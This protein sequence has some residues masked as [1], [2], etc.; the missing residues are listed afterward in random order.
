MTDAPRTERGNRT[1]AKLLVAAEAVF[2]ECGYSDAS[3]VRITEAAG[4]A[5]GTFYLYFTSKLE[6]FEELVED[7]NRRVRHAMTEAA[8]GS[9]SR[10]ESERAGFR[11][12]F[13]FTA[14]HPALYRIVREAEFVSPSALRLHYSRIV[15]G[16]ISGLGGAQ[17]Q[18]EVGDF[19]PEIVA[20]ILMGIGEM[21]GMRWVLWGNEEAAGAPNDPTASG[22][23]TVPQEV[24]EQMMQFIQRGLGAPSGGRQGEAVGVHSAG[25]EQGEDIR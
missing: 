2:A 3:I 20:W 21:V 13:E 17:Q 19:D 10:I 22:T 24:F 14:E 5:Q 9:A 25:V 8:A 15:E 16:Y 7:L 23:S 6:I 11:A 18:G 1:R 4:V 12:F